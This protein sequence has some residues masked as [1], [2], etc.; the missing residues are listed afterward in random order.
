MTS[1]IKPFKSSR[2]SNVTSVDTTCLNVFEFPKK[3]DLAKC[4]AEG[5]FLGGVLN[6]E[7]DCSGPCF[8]WVMSNGNA[9]NN[10]TKNWRGWP[11]T[12][13]GPFMMPEG[14]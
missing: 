12:L 7:R 6:N 5:I 13:R 1:A 10:R 11:N 14:T 2:L 8:N 9:S 3:E 4:M